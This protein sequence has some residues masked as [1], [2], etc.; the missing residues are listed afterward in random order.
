MSIERAWK[1]LYCVSKNC[2][3][4]TEVS[5]IRIERMS[6]QLISGRRAIAHHL[7]MRKK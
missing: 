6:I 2:V 5:R 4:L 7:G 1:D 3:Y